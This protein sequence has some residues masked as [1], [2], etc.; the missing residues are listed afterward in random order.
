M[1]TGEEVSLKSS[2]EKYALYTIAFTQR[3]V[4]GRIFM[5]MQLLISMMLTLIISRNLKIKNIEL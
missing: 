1:Q 5:R 2:R 4:K 3:Q